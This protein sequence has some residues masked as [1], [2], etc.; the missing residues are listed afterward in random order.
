ME[1]ENSTCAEITSELQIQIFRFFT[2]GI[3]SMVYNSKLLY[4]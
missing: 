1:L 2:N 4:I 3:L